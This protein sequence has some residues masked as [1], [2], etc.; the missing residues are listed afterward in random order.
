MDEVGRN[1]FIVGT[2]DNTGNTRGSRG[3]LEIDVLTLLALADVCH[4]LGN[5]SKDIIKLPYF[6]TVSWW[7]L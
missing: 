6:K 4:H 7:C 1:K 2:C 3:M 5:T